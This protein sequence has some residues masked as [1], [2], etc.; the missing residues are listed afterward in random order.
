MYT[1]KRISRMIGTP[2]FRSSRSNLGMRRELTRRLI[3]IDS[4]RYFCSDS[5][6]VD[7]INLSSFEIRAPDA[8]TG[9]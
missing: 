7:S 8:I 4:I 5:P 1:G 9:R 2:L 6:Y 3:D